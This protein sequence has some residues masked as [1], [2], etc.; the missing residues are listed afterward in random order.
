MVPDWRWTFQKYQ[1][2]LDVKILELECT[3]GVSGYNLPLS[4]FNRSLL[5]YRLPPHKCQLCGLIGEGVFEEGIHIMGRMAPPEEA[6]SIVGHYKWFRRR[7]PDLC[8][9]AIKKALKVNTGLLKMGGRFIHPHWR[10]LT[11]W[12]TMFG[13]VEYGDL[14][15]MRDDTMDWLVKIRHVG[16]VVGEAQYL[17]DLYNE[18]VNFLRAEWRMPDPL[19]SADMW[20]KGGVWMRGK[21]GTGQKTEIMVEGKKHR[22]RAYKG[23]DAV[24][25]SD[26]HIR[27]ELFTVCN[28]RMIVMQKSEGGKIRACVKTGNELYRKMDF[29]SEIVENGLLGSDTSTLFAGPV[30][31]EAIDQGWLRSVRDPHTLKVPLDQS[32]FDHCQSYSSIIAVMAAVGDVCFTTAGVPDDYRKCWD[33][34][35]DTMVGG[36]VFVELGKERWAWKNGIPSGWRWTALF[37]TLL[38]IAS[39]KVVCRYV[40]EDW[41]QPVPV[42]NL[43]AQ[44]DDVLWET[45]GLR[46]VERVVAVYAALGYQVHP[47]KTYISQDRA[48][49][50]RRSYETTGITGYSS[51]TQ[52]SVRFRNPIIEMPLAPAERISSR[53]ALWMLARQRG[54]SALPVAEMI[55]EDALQA[56]VSH[57]D[58]VDFSLTPGSAGGLGLHGSDGSVAGYLEH[59][60]LGTGRWIIPK[61]EVPSLRLRPFLGYWKERFARLGLSLTGDYETNFSYMLAQTWGLRKAEITGKVTVSWVEVE[62]FSPS[63]S[64]N[65]GLLRPHSEYWDLQHVPTLLR[66]IVQSLAVENDDYARY[67]KPSLY[68]E[69]MAV[70]RRM[71]TAVFKVYLLGRYKVPMPVL[72]TVSLKYG[73]QIKKKA[74]VRMRR[75]MAIANIDLKAL[76]RKMLW[77]EKWIAEQVSH[78]YGTVQYAL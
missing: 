21:A 38:N 33:A 52:L 32:S 72:D 12:E 9:H 54:A 74:D 70:R 77:L 61:I 68:H 6:S 35:W 50:L 73:H 17:E 29:L 34:L 31:N 76:Q 71:S 13:Y 2:E 23:V 60:G 16:E 25:K 14:E 78:E 4:D 58:M 26:E 40:K 56:G 30:G 53:V 49:F 36:R 15:D 51:R 43:C 44:G 45:A 24:L 11:Y 5:R 1:T 66:G 19:P 65:L 41:G 46:G 3:C 27:R 55:L 28:E 67:I 10:V 22:T 7:Y 63:P 47:Q 75:Y 18:V 48:E 57:A 64:F 42:Y 39:F 59:T 62:K 37:D 8:Q 20:V 69:L